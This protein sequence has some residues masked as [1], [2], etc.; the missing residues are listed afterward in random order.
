MTAEEPVRVSMLAPWNGGGVELCERLALKG[1]ACRVV[2]SEEEMAREIEEK[3]PDVLLVEIHS[4]T[5]DSDSWQLVR[6]LAKTVPMIALVPRAIL[7]NF[8]TRFKSDDFL[9]T[10]PD[11]QEL[12]LRIKRLAGKKEELAKGTPEKHRGLIIDTSSCEV[13]IDGRVIDL[14][15][16]EYELLKLL[17]Q[18]KGH[19][20]TREVLLDKLWGYDYFGGDRTVD[21]HVRRLRSKIED[22][23]HTYIETVRNIGYR[24]KRDEIAGFVT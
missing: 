15:F 14:T 16:K 17:A 4:N 9:V 8:D 2:S 18:D 20:Y 11:E 13:T 23:R 12:I 10:P 24:F 3:A 19:V 1:I 5:L 21:V 6:D 7:S 22:A